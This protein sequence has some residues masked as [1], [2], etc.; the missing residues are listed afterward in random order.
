MIGSAE[1]RKVDEYRFKNKYNLPSLLNRQIDE[2]RQQLTTVRNA[3]ITLDMDGEDYEEQTIIEPL[4]WGTPRDTRTQTTYT[5]AKN[6]KVTPANKINPF[7]QGIPSFA[8]S[9][10]K[11]IFE[12]PIEFGFD[13]VA[14]S[15]F[16]FNG[17]SKV[18]SLQEEPR[19][20]RIWDYIRHFNVQ[21]HD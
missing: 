17:H 18:F 8:I 3:R 12:S 13:I 19:F 11:T 21:S 4:N 20:C 1:L 5:P 2:K 9:I 6:K 16:G 15:H 14:K 10:T 7:F